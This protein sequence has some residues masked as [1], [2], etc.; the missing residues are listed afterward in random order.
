MNHHAWYQVHPPGHMG[1]QPPA[2]AAV[3]SEAGDSE[4]ESDHSPPPP[5]ARAAWPRGWRLPA[6]T[7]ALLMQSDGQRSS[8]AVKFPT[9]HASVAGCAASSEG[10]QTPTSLAKPPMHRRIRHLRR[11]DRASW[12]NDG[13]VAAAQAQSAHEPQ[14]DFRHRK[15]VYLRPCVQR[16]ASTPRQPCP[17]ASPTRGRRHG[18]NPGRRSA[19]YPDTSM[20]SIGTTVV[21]VG[22]ALLVLPPHSRSVVETRGRPLK[23]GLRGQI[24]SR[25]AAD[26]KVDPGSMSS[27]SAVDLCTTPGPDLKRKLFLFR[28]GSTEVF[29][30]FDTRR[31][32]TNLAPKQTRALGLMRVNA[33]R[34]PW[35]LAGERPARKYSPKSTPKAEI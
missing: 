15:K 6:V 33:S 1:C 20:A 35:G 12:E 11:G 34:R 7:R 18:A 17:N 31:G 19:G 28:G 25:S 26:A 23:L 2:D 32:P 27:R 13:R 14:L 22:A 29:R 30:A 24:L 9:D 21:Q 16:K 8:P 5:L 3:L 4:P 10:H